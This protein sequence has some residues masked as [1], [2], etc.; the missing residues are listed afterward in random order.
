MKFNELKRYIFKDFEKIRIAKT[1]GHCEKDFLKVNV[2]SKFT[3]LNTHMFLG[4]NISLHK[5]T[6]LVG[7]LTNHINN[8]SSNSSLNSMYS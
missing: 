6:D 8:I 1:K 3:K 7:F 5:I 2:K 4:L